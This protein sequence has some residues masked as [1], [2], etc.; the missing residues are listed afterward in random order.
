MARLLFYDDTHRYTV[1]GEE[2][3]SVSELTRFLTREVY[4]DT[5]QYF[6]DGAAARGTLVHRATESLDKYGT[7]EC[8]DDIAPY[9]Q[10]YVQFV[11]DQAPEWEKIEWPVCMGKRY[12]GTV[13]RYGSLDGKKTIL[14]IKTTQHISGMHKV[15]YRAQLN[16][17]RL[18]V[19]AEKPVEEMVILQLK[20]DGSYKLIPLEED[21]QL[22]LA[23]LTMHEAIKN[24]KT[25]RRKK[26]AQS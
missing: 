13:D 14:D 21:E 12:A 26:D 17:Y 11:K 1:D 25:K 19:E 16:L 7:V 4:T 9:L 3:P 22:A 10:A 23:C 18:A 6:M 20:K 5:P 15:L 24:S 2:V 8:E